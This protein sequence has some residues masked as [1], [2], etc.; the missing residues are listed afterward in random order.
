LNK[1]MKMFG[2]EQYRRPHGDEGREC[3][4]S[5]YSEHLPSME[6]TLELIPEMEPSQILDI[7]CGGGMCINLLLK[8]Y[9]DAMGHGVDISEE[10]I[11][12][13]FDYNKGYIDAGRAEFRLGEVSHLPYPDDMFDIVMATSTYFFWPD[14]RNDIKEIS[15][16][17]RKGAVLLIS[18]GAD[19]PDT[20]GLKPEARKEVDGMNIPTHD[21]MLSYYDDAG[22]DGELFILEGDFP[23]VVYRG[24]KR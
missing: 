1:V 15:R 18:G 2:I 4:Q 9:P 11:E 7:G 19:R 6:R 24:V 12:A 8:R 10:C 21:Q 17:M 13:S 5:M 3:I 16:T 20:E 14:L 22:L 23:W